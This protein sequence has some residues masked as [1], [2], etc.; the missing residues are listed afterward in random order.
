MAVCR[1]NIN[2]DFCFENAVNKSVLFGNLS[3][4]PIFG[5]AFQRLGMSSS[6]CGVYD[7][8]VEKFNGFFET[9]RLVSFQFGKPFLSFR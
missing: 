6:S 9:F 1:K 8:L 5:L 4:P 3:A 2:M 7:N